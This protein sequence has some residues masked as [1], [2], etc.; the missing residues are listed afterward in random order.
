MRYVCNAAVESKRSRKLFGRLAVVAGLSVR[1]LWERRISRSEGY[2]RN[3]DD[4]ME[5]ALGGSNLGEI[6]MEIAEVAGK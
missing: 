3:W 4:E 1:H 5:P 6:D 2:R